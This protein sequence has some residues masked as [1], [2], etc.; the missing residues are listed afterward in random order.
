MTIKDYRTSVNS[1]PY[2]IQIKNRSTKLFYFTCYQPILPADTSI[3]AWFA[4]PLAINT[5]GYFIWHATYDMIW[6][7]TGP[8]RIGDV[9]R[10]GQV[11]SAQL[12]SSNETTFTQI[13][14]AYQFGPETDG[15]PDKLTIKT[16]GTI[17]NDSVSIGTGMSQRP[18]S[19]LQASSNSPTAFIPPQPSVY[20]LAFSDTKIKNGQVLDLNI[21]E[22]AGCVIKFPLNQ[23][24]AIAELTEGNTWNVDYETSI[25]VI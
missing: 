6:A 9:V 4:E 14:G 8:L 20:S 21:L 7:E 12:S 16:D 10:A 1:E 22:S 3:L 13:N 2:V 17:P 23:F 5:N 11:R 25:D 18:V 15:A 24:G 19:A